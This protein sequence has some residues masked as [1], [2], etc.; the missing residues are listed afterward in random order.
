M[1]DGWQFRPRR[2]VT[3]A[4]I[5]FCGLTVALGLW[6]TRRAAEKEAAQAR[7]DRLAVEPPISLSSALVDPAAVAFRRVSARGDYVDRYSILLDNKVLRGRVGYQVV[8]PLRIAGSDMH[9]LVNRGWVAAGRTRNAL[10]QVPAPTGE[11]TIAGIVVVP[12]ARF[13][14]LAPESPQG[15]VW[16]NLVLERYHAW[17][18]LALQPVVIEQTNDA[19][20]GLAREWDRPDAGTARH[21]SYALQWFA[22]AA[23]TLVLYVALNL[24]RRA[25]SRD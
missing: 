24:K 23:L 4:A 3:L 19:R 22:F 17:S 18:G 1:N 12:S 7:L 25:G 9:V 14:E 20:D 6:Q 10:P 5:L 2:L 13:Y 11:Q 16:E 21:R 15:P 8:S